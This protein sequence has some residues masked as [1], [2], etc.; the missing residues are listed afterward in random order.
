LTLSKE[1]YWNFNDAHFTETLREVEGIEIDR[2]TVG[3][4]VAGKVEEV[5][6]NRQP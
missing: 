5:R 3:G 6:S 2:E 4:M 1:L